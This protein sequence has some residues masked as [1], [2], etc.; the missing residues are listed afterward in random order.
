MHNDRRFWLWTAKPVQHGVDYSDVETLMQWG[1][2]TTHEDT[3]RG[4]LALIYWSSPAKYLS[5]LVEA[6]SNA[7]SIEW[8]GLPAWACDFK[9]HVRLAHALTQIGRAHV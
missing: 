2:W 7:Y 3:K 5:Y 1:S 8:D 9:T 4:D 6:T